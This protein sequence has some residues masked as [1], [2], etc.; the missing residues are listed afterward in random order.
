MKSGKRFK[1]IQATWWHYLDFFSVPTMRQVLS[2]QMSQTAC[3]ISFFVSH[4][5]L[6]FA[7]EEIDDPS[8][9][10]DFSLDDDNSFNVNRFRVLWYSNA[11]IRNW[12]DNSLILSNFSLFH[13][14]SDYF[15]F[16]SSTFPLLCFCFT[17]ASY[18]LLSQLKP[19]WPCIEHCPAEHSGVTNMRYH[20][21]WA[22]SCSCRGKLKRHWALIRM[23]KEGVRG[24][25]PNMTQTGKN[26]APRI[27]LE[28]ARHEEGRGCSID[29]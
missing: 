17:H 3:F 18:P 16:H 14:P 25:E 27:A 29:D 7:Q 1:V 15:P 26:V 11:Y 19:W 6:S 21:L 20:A 13:L 9:F 10:P 28:Y 12:N 5:H 22:G 23:L 24:K 4:N 2:N 8:D